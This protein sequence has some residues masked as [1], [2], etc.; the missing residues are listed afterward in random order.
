MATCAV[1]GEGA[2]TAAALCVELG[3]SPRNLSEHHSDL[4]VR[5][6]LRQ[7]ASVLGLPLDDEHDLVQS[8]DVSASSALTSI[9][10][11]TGT[12]RHR[13]EQDLGIVIPVDPR[14]D[15][16]A[17]IVDATDDTELVVTCYDP[18]VG[19]NYRPEVEVAKTSMRVSTGTGQRIAAALPFRPPAPGNAFVVLQANPAVSVHVVPEPTPGVLCLV[20]STSRTDDQASGAAW[21][22]KP[23]HRRTVCL[24]VS[25]PTAAF[26]PAK[27]CDGYLPPFAGRTRGCRSRGAGDPR[28]CSPSGLSR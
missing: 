8:A 26:A 14:L 18:V 19:Q 20:R 16:I 22:A 2:G 9:D 25:P 23:L 7:D 6:L 11:S 24:T 17:F 1:I 10:V 4:L 15:S 28:G 27:A 5:T 21:S 12:D 13:L 3:E